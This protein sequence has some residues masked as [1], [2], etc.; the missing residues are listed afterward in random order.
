MENNYRWKII[1]LPMENNY[2]RTCLTKLIPPYISTTVKWLCKTCRDEEYNDKSLQLKISQDKKLG[3]GI[4]IGH[5]NVRSLLTKTKKDD[6]ASI[7][8]YHDFDV[9]A[10][11][12]TWLKPEI[13]D[14]EIEINNYSVHRA[15]R[16]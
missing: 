10:V 6:I 14:G 4:K 5:L 11:T 7:I 8:L 2:H 1:P 9:F 3:R 12:E 13:S 16:P 15:D